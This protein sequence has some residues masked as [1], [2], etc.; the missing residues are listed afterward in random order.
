VKNSI[1]RTLLG[2]TIIAF[3][4]GCFPSSIYK[5]TTTSPTTTAPPTAEHSPL[6]IS[7]GPLLLIQSGFNAY[8]ILNILEK[9]AYQFTPPGEPG[10]HHL[11]NNLSPS[12]KNMIFLINDELP[13]IMSFETWQV[14]ILDNLYKGS[15]IFQSGK[16]ARESLEVLPSLNFTYEAI[17]SAV[18]K[19]LPSSKSNLQWYQNDSTLL[20]VQEG[21][22]TSTNLCL[23]DLGTGTQY[24]L[25]EKPG[26]VEAYWVSPDEEKI[27]VKK[28]FIF[29]PN[30]WEDDQYFVVDIASRSAEPVPLPQDINHPSLSWLGSQFVGITHQTQPAGGVGFSL[31]DPTTMKST[32]IINEDFT[33]IRLYDEHLLVIRQDQETKT[34]IIKQID[35]LGQVIR[36]QALDQLCVIQHICCEKI[37]LNCDTES[38]ILDEIF[39]PRS[40]GNPIFLLSPSPDGQTFVLITRTNAVFLLNAVLE[41]RQLLTLNRAPLEIRWLPDSSG[42]LYRTPGELF[43]YDLTSEK[44]HLLLT[45]DL[46]GDY[47]NL[48][49]VWI[50]IK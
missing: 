31:M 48:N 46:F 33:Q 37:I 34:S 43:Y 9:T 22:Q 49:A 17:L 23:N 18:E 25:E 32:Q 16:T 20:F 12:G 3:L 38:L 47:R 41:E 39:H 1:I 35:F 29:E 19:A 15:S 30:I 28:G 7:D 11:A 44:S 24:Q 6:P 45:S 5:Q 21:S 8:H 40:F 36:S 50:N 10:Y 4:N 27:L 2:L 26:L 42:F 14:K 13:G